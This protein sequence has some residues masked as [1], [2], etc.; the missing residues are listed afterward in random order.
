MVIIY[1]C[2]IEFCSIVITISTVRDWCINSLRL[3]WQN[4]NYNYGINDI[5]MSIYFYLSSNL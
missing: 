4:K 1:Y 5:P 2:D 3:P